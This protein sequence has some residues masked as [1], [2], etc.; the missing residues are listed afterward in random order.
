MRLDFA[1]VAIKIAHGLLYKYLTSIN[2]SNDNH[3]LYVNHFHSIGLKESCSLIVFITLSKF[4]Q[5][6]RF[7]MHVKIYT[8]QSPLCYSLL[9]SR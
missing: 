5:Y 1:G 8:C 9:P 2:S 6:F 4:S 7:V 3:S